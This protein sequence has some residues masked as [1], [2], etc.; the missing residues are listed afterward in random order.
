MGMT[1]TELAKL[2]HVSRA[3]VDRVFNNRGRV[4]GATRKR[5]LEAADAAGYCPNAVAQS[6]VTGRTRSLGVLVPDLNNAFFSALLNA[7][8]RR[9]QGRGYSTLVSLYEDGPEYEYK[10]A[11][12]LLERQAD[13]IVV[14]STSKSGDSLRAAGER[15]VPAVAMLN[16]AG[17]VPCVSVDYRQAMADAA[18]YVI[19]KGYADLIFLC[20]PLARAANENMHALLRRLEGLEKAVAMRRGDGAH[21]T[22]IDTPDYMDRLGRLSFPREEKTAILCSSDIYAMKAMKLLKTRGVRV[23]QDIGI[24]GCDGIEALEYMEPSVATISIPI[25]RL[26]ETAVDYLLDC[27]ENGKSEIETTLQYRIKPG[28]SII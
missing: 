28:Q 21:L 4:S 2:C 15:N 19:G 6:L 18:N 8:A 13:G 24:M 27:I 16:E 9:A 12:N 22:V 14:F 20:P 11:L 23:P 3:T 1:S 26:G 5:I 25:D 7:A 10:C 17:G